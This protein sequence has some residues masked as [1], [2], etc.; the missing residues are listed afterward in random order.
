MVMKLITLD[1]EGTLVDFQ[2]KVEEAVAEIIRLMEAKNIPGDNFVN[3]DYAGIYNLVQEKGEQW[4]FGDG[5]LVALIDDIYDRYDYDAASRWAAV[6]GL[7]QILAGFEGFKL[8]L[9]SN[10]GRKGISKMLTQFSLEDSFGLVLTRDDVRFLKPS[11]E[12]IF[13]AMAWAGS[14]NNETVHIGDSL[15]DLFAARNAG[16]TSGIVLGGQDTPEAII[17]EKPDLILENLGEF[18]RVLQDG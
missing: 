9:V 3:L 10:V 13:K 12:G 1:W 6:E 8:A 14:G 16:V 18:P 11:P 15:S 4:G 5:S 17:R 7:H 2:W